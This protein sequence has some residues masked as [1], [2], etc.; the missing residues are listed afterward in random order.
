MRLI[1][2][3][4]GGAPCS[5]NTGGLRQKPCLITGSVVRVILLPLTLKAIFLKAPST[6]TWDVLPL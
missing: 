3:V 6:V 2:F 5:M 4:T 1:F